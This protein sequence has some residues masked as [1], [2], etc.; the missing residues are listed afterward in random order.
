MTVLAFLIPV[1][2]FMGVVGL[3][4]FFWSLRSGQYEDLSGAAERI[5]FDEDRP[6]AAR[7]K[8]QPA[9]LQ[10]A[11]SISDTPKGSTP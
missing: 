11:T 2:L 8:L 7:P 1:T 3:F 5:I 6:I 4:A 9:A 10:S